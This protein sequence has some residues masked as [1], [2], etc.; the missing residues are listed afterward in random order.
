MSVT[1]DRSVVFSGYS[2]YLH[3]YNWPPRYSWNIVESDVQHHQINKQ[4][5]K[6]ISQVM[7]AIELFRKGHIS[8]LVISLL[9]YIHIKLQNNAL[10]SKVNAGYLYMSWM[11]ISKAFF[12][13]VY[14]NSYMY[15]YLYLIPF[16]LSYW[17]SFQCSKSFDK[18]H[19]HFEI[20]FM[21]LFSSKSRQFWYFF[22][23]SFL[24]ICGMLM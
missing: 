10:R 14:I 11:P 15:A 17:I 9:F 6:Q 24:Q 19:F 7:V 23:K 22:F 20:I 3:Q 18:H 2:G 12:V 1:C 5:N 16:Y 13:H 21:A 4:A 8:S